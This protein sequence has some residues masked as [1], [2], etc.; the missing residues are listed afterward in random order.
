MSAFNSTL[1]HSVASEDSQ[2][3]AGAL[4]VAAV[5][6]TTAAYYA[7]GSKGKENEFPK[8]PGIQPYHAWNFFK[9][10]YD[11]LR[12]GYKRNEGKPFYFNILQHKII[13][14]T[15]DDARQVFFG[16]PHLNVDEGYKILMGAAP[17]MSNVT[18]ATEEPEEGNYGPFNRRLNKLMHKTRVEQ[19]FPTLIQDIVD[20]ADKWGN[21]G[22]SGKIDPFNEIYELLF[23]MTARLTTCHDLTKNETDLKRIEIL[24]ME[25]QNSA[26]P[27]SLMISWFASPAKMSGLL[28]TTELFTILR[29][30]VDKRRNAVPTTDAI[31]VLIADGETTQVIIEFVMGVLFAGLLNTGIVACW[32]LIDLAVHPEWKAKCKKEVEDLISRHLGDS[33]TFATVYDKLSSVPFTA[34]EDELPILEA[35]TRES[36]RLSFTGAALRRNVREDIKI[37]GKLVKR[38]DFLTYPISEVHLS[39]EFY[40]DPHKY[41]P[42]RWLRPDPVPNAVYPYLGWGA[43]RHPCPGMKVAKLEMKLITA[44]F[45]MRYEYE[46]E[47]KDGNFPNPLP[48]PN[49]NDIHQARP[50][51]PTCYFKFKKVVD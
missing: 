37:G 42:G 22:K 8:L 35:C 18:V 24:L 7:L 28:A 3:L 21:N 38:G 2:F 5:F 1:F 9:Q 14:L 31:D 10:R 23:L 40:P 51:G 44:M 27:V 29:S 41:D 34:W 16:S 47:D 13:A 50:L 11:F 4:G 6:V 26:T 43:G 46:L 49:R 20:K 32:T 33:D 17:R 45:L 36:Q 12:S 15:G 19:I 25:L 48:V 30:Y 39:S